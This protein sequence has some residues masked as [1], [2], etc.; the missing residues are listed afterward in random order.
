MP[1]SATR[2]IAR[3]HFLPQAEAQHAA[4]RHRLDGVLD[5]IQEH[6]DKAAHIHPDFVAERN[7]RTR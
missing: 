4:V 6:P 7:S 2:K 3:L 1:V 5:Q